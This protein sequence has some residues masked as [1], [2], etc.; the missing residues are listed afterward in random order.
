M[1]RPAFA[2]AVAVVAI[3][4]CGSAHAAPITFHFT[5]DVT[6]V[7]AIEPA[8]FF[9]IEPSFGTTFSGFFTFDSIAPDL[10]PADATTG[11]YSSVGAPFGLT[12]ELGGRTFTYG[13]V[14][15]GVTNGYSSIGFG[16]DE[17][18]FGFSDF[19]AE[20]QTILSARLTDLT[21]TMFSGDGLPLQ[22]PVGSDVSSFFFAFTDL[23]DP[24]NEVQVD[25]NGEIT[26]LTTVPEPATLSLLAFGLGGLAMRR[27]ARRTD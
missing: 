24:D 19:G 21:G 6:S 13:A 8:D 3:L 14:S 10:V 1:K 17:Y 5:G 4:W 18:L 2:V 25:L 23:T 15:I 7:G 27:R 26:S 11:A 20:I 12:L 22:P 16:S 9:P